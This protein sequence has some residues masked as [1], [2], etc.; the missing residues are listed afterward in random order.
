MAGK[1]FDLKVLISGIDKLSPMLSATAK[2]LKDWKLQAAAFGKGGLAMGAGVAAGLGVSLK[3][4]ADQEDA[5][6]GLRVALMGEGGKVADEFEHITALANKLGDKLPGTTADFQN[7]MTTLVRQG[8]PAQSILDGVGESAALLAVQLRMAPEAAAEF[9]AKMQDS[10]KTVAT[11]MLGLMD[12]IQRTFYLGVDPENM[13]QGF[14][15]LSPAMDMIKKTGLEGA[16]ALAPLIVMADQAGMSGEAAGNA[17]RKVIAA[18]FD[19]EKVRKANAIGAKSGI[20]L[21]FTNGKGEFGGLDNL[22]KQLDKLRK[23]TTQQRVG[24]L[25][26]L[27]GDDAEV[28]QAV[29]LLIEKNALGYGETLDKMRAQADLN[30]RVAA[31]L[32][33]LKNLFDAM[34]GSAVNGLAAIGQ[35]F[36]GEA[37]Q[38]AEFLGVMANRLTELAA[39]NPAVIR[40]LT[41][42][43]GVLALV[44]IGA[45]GV[46][47][48]IAAISAAATMSPLGIFLRLAALGVGL[49]LA[50]WSTV[51]PFFARLWNK[52]EPVL[53]LF[54][55]GLLA[56]V[57]W[58]PLGF[59]IRN[60]EPIVQWFASLWQR[61]QPYVQ[62]LL[63]GAS[64]ALGK[65]GAGVAAADQ[66]LLAAGP[67]GGLL[68][69][70]T[71]R[72][73][74]NGEI[75][76][77]FDNAPPGT[78]VETGRTSQPGVALNP[79]VGYR[80][81]ALGVP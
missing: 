60:W 46:S 16:K 11:D 9:A 2:K 4:F 80:S 45:L 36:S 55:H 7:M 15:K 69:A 75:T 21:D 77:K 58:S 6:T 40:T 14:A 54:W 63:D 66:R 20:K 8:I 70:A 1:T 25:K 67:R 76:V 74:L 38:L 62:P 49:L 5:A 3:A 27:F 56:I 29:S 19:M 23:L 48:G 41:A 79:D 17:M 50:N 53:T 32:A 65:L 73:Q 81:A 61:V 31:Q 35:A 57:D 24:L 72:Q 44:K 59:V 18:G 13:L 64:W 12:V 37:K 78:R 68:D 42:M 33:T 10:T 52:I 34:T 28:L 47:W 71:G 43:V 26:E 30:T 51:G 22:F 39:T